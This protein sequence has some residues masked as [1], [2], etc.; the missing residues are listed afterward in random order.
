MP[1]LSVSYPRHVPCPEFDGCR[2]N[3]CAYPGEEACLHELSAE[4]RALRFMASLRP[5]HAW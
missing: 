2:E 3:Y 1:A 4:D 5:E